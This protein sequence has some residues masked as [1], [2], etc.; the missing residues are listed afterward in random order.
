MFITLEGPDGGG[1]SSQLGPLAEY[2]RQEGYRVLTTREPGGTTIGDRVRQVLL[3]P[4]NTGMQPRTEVLLFQA[5][6]AQLVE[7]VIRPHLASGWVVICDRYADS[8]LAYQGYGQGGDLP[9][10][11]ALLDYATGGLKPDLTLLL[12][13]DAEVG[14]HRIASRQ[15]GYEDGQW[16]RLDANTLAYHERVRAGYHELAQMEPR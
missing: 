4:A 2:L 11:R 16:N 1:K 6:R 9:V 12:D 5:S 13:V 3:D 7:Q 15:P 10:L 14:I 8:T